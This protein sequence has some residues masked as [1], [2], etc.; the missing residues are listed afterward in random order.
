MRT[1]TFTGRDGQFHTRTNPVFDPETALPRIIPAADLIWQS[2]PAVRITP[3]QAHL[4]E[5]GLAVRLGASD[6]ANAQAKAV[7]A[8]N[9]DDQDDQKKGGHPASHRGNAPASL[10]LGPDDHRVVALCEGT[11]GM[12]VVGVLEDHGR[13]GLR[14]RTILDQSFVRLPHTDGTTTDRTTHH[15]GNHPNHQD[16]QDH[17]EDA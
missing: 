7:L 15:A 2:L 1:K 8:V 17:Q 6:A 13:H 5:T 16:H 11:D 14:P 4:L 9:A 3:V 10:T 12:I